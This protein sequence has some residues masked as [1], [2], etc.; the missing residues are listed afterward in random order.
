[1]EEVRQTANVLCLQ[2]PL[3]CQHF[4]DNRLGPENRDEI[5]LPE[6]ALNQQSPDQVGAAEWRNLHMVGFPPLHQSRQNSEVCILGWSAPR[7][8][9]QITDSLF[10]TQ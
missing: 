5:L 4:R 1:M 6:S 3:A 9:E 2:L 7:L 10:D 8:A